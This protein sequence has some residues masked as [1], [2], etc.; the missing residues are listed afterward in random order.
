MKMIVL[1]RYAHYNLMNL[2]NIVLIYC[3][4]WDIVRYTSHQVIK[5]MVWISGVEEMVN[6][7][8]FNVKDIVMR[9]Q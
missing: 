6:N 5:M 4:C 9:H 3:D 8:P 1:R 2:R 7:S